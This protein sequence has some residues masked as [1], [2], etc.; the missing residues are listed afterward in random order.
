MRMQRRSVLVSVLGL[1]VMVWVGIVGVAQAQGGGTSAATG[2]ETATPAKAAANLLAM[3]EGECMSAA[4][5]MP[6]DKYNFSP[7][8]LA[9]AGAKFEGV[10][11]FADQVKHL[12]QANLYFASVVSGVKADGEM[13]AV[14]A[15]KEKD[16]IVSALANSFTALHKA[17]ATL[18]IQNAFDIVPFEGSTAAK[19]SVASFAVAHGFDHYGQMVEYLRMNGIVPPA[20][21]K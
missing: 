14:G 20:S 6:A 9:I 8:S 10:R 17:N 12:A 2:T 7:A 18:T 21:A 1:V 19:S 13:K 4:K 3:L 11:T 15:L 16:A 5:A